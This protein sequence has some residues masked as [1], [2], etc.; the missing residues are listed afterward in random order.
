MKNKIAFYTLSFT[1]GL[2]MTLIGLISACVLICAGRKPKRWGGCLCF[3]VGEK[4]GGLNLG[5][6]IVT[7]RW[8]SKRI[9]NHEFGHAIQNC[10]YGLMMPIFSI[11]SVVR[12]WYRA[13]ATIKGVALKTAYDDF[14]LEGE[15]TKLGNKYI[16]YWG[17]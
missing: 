13:I 3:T 16:G 15:A 14:W 7:D 11:I 17:D 2:P 1:W 9:K 6:V 4:W 10:R 5:I 8:D 12:Y